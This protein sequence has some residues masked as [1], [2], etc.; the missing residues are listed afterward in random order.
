MHLDLLVVLLQNV[1]LSMRINKLNFKLKK[2]F[3]NINSYLFCDRSPAKPQC[4]SKVRLGGNCQGFSKGELNINIFFSLIIKSQN[5]IFIYTICKEF[6]DRIFWPCWVK[7][8]FLFSK[9]SGL[10]QKSS[11][12]QNLNRGHNLFFWYFTRSDQYSGAEKPEYWLNTEKP[13][14]AHGP[15][16][17]L[18]H[19]WVSAK[20]K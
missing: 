17:S 8:W 9:T 10:Y 13:D 16:R 11:L 3:K 1:D 2:Y 15:V 4:V 18:F 14:S 5:Y 7:I 19:M 6:T 12:S 20:I